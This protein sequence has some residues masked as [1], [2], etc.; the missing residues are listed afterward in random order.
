MKN[1]QNSA[2]KRELP[3]ELAQMFDNL[4]KNMLTKNEN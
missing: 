1:E 2:K 4:R 3:P